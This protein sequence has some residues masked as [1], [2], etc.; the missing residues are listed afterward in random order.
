[1]IACA[2]V[3]SLLLARASSREH[4]LAVRLSIGAGRGR[5]VRQLLAESLLL[6]FL[7]T[8]A[9][10]ALN[11]VLTSLVNGVRFPLPLPI[12]FLIQPDWRLMTYATA[13]AVA[14]SLLCGLMPALRGTRSTINIGLKRSDRQVG[15]R[16]WN[17]RN[18][19]VVGQLAVS[20]V[21]LSAGF[22]FLRNLLIAS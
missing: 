5:L 8:V 10:L 14:S 21:L 17:L 6:A 11:L 2:N 19:L 4:E 16:A 7:G 15:A 12:Q 1:L 9:A 3:A 20:I 13:A 22:L 18:A